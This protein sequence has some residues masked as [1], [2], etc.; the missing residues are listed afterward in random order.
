MQ[1]SCILVI[2]VAMMITC[3]SGIDQVKLSKLKTQ[4]LAQTDSVPVN[5]R[6]GYRFLRSYKTEEAGDATDNEDRAL[7]LKSLKSFVRIK[8]TPNDF[9]KKYLKRML[10]DPKFKKDMFAKWKKDYP[11]N[12][13][14]SKLIKKDPAM[15]LDFMNGNTA[16]RP[17]N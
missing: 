1:R 7:D 6:N 13:I 5:D 3:C 4:D 11:H 2:M 12:K 10:T 8:K 17:L 14:T 9:S 16:L 15:L